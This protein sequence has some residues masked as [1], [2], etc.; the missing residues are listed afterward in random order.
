MFKYIESHKE[1]TIYIPLTLYWVILFIF[2]SLPASRV[3]DVGVNDKIEHYTAFFILGCLLIL[4]FYYQDGSKF[5]KKHFNLGT[6][7]LGMFYGAFDE[8][9]QKYVPGRSC[10]LYDWI[11]DTCGIL[12]AIGFMFLLKTWNA[13]KN[14]PSTE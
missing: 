11:A 3:P 2:T 12:I 13:S 1:Y 8:L 5:W 4:M 7:F 9:H 14:K 6:L 10:D